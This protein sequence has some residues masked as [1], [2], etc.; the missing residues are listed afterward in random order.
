METETNPPNFK[1]I[2]GDLGLDFV[3]TV[4]GWIDHDTNT[5]IAGYQHTVLRDKLQTY[6]DL[7]VWGL[8][9]NLISEDERR[10]LASLAARRPQAAE[11][12]LERAIR[13]RRAFY[14]MLTGKSSNTVTLA[15]DLAAIN[16]E[17]SRARSQQR[18]YP[19]AQ[20]FAYGWATDDALDRIL[21][22]V[23]IAG[24]ALLTGKDRARLRQCQGDDC[25]WL[26]LDTS[27]NRSRTWC[28]MGDCGNVA[29]VRRYRAR[30]AE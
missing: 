25:G 7:L 28:S 10:R 16:A 30:Q 12:V 24:C 20:A 8:A 5:D 23:A 27:R 29:K 21:W 11:E 14:R 17:L 3:N 9:A 13:L 22:P 18:I 26:F 2:A 6:N 19:S 4:G 15:S 1:F